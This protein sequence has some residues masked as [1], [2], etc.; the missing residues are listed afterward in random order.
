[1]YFILVFKEFNCNNVCLWWKCN[2]HS[3]NVTHTAQ[4]FI[5]EYSSQ[6]M[7]NDWIRFFKKLK[8]HIQI[9]KLKILHSLEFNSCYLFRLNDKLN[10]EQNIRRIPYIEMIIFK[11]FNSVQ[12]NLLHI[13]IL[14]ILIL[15]SGISGWVF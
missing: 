3:E 14:Y 2:T 1:M 7:Y 13:S 6:H 9:H 5:I 4:C 11:N 8:R 12:H 15:I 10:M